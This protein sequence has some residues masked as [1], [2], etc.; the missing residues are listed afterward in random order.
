MKSKCS[1]QPHFLNKTPKEH[2][3]YVQ[4]KHNVTKGEPHKTISGFFYH[5]LNES[6]FMISSLLFMRTIFFFYPNSQKYQFAILISLGLALTFY[7]TS[8]KTLNAWIYMDLCHE[9][10]IQEKQ[11]MENHPDQEREET[12][13]IFSNQG[14]TGPLLEQIT[15]YVCS[16][17]TLQLNTMIKE[18][19]NIDLG[20]YP[21]PIKQALPIL[22]GNLVALISFTPAVLCVSY[23]MA[24][25]FAC[26]YLIIISF[27]KARILKR[28]P[29]LESVWVCSIL[30]ASLGMAMVIMKLLIQK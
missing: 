12:S 13:L 6:M 25:S 4:D 16:D 28:S 5:L 18:E 8:Y 1:F 11:E 21:H 2:V 23:I 10:I 3:S 29:I 15:D 9:S 14:F 7:R 22:Y 27:I 30:V 19:L 26:L 17:T 20:T 24:M